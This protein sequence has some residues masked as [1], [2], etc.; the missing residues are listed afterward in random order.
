MVGT[1]FEEV[2]MNPVINKLKNLAIDR[3]SG[4]F[5]G[6]CTGVCPEKS[7]ELFDDYLG[8]PSYLNTP[9]SLSLSISV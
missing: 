2:K 6:T 4:R 1:L 9:F 5:C 7:P 8:R 3:R